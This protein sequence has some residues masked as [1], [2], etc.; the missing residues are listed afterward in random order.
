ML[1]FKH[2]RRAA[3]TIAGIELMHRI[4]KGQFKLGKLGVKDKTAPKTWNA[5]LAA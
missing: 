1:S 5:V 3:T 2:F 4:R